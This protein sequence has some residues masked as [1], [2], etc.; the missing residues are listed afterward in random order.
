MEKSKT[1]ISKQ[2]FNEIK[3]SFKSLLDLQ[4][5]QTIDGLT[6]HAYIVFSYGFETFYKLETKSKILKKIL[7]YS[8]IK[9]QEYAEDLA[10]CLFPKIRK[11]SCEFSDKRDEI[12]NKNPELFNIFCL[13]RNFNLITYASIQR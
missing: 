7:E 10:F 4:S 3:N 5:S 1:E 6:C 2:E 13:A 11:F 8:G 12:Y 9:N